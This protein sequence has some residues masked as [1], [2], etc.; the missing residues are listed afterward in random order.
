MAALAQASRRLP[1]DEPAQTVP[2]ERSGTVEHR[3]EVGGSRPR[4]R[5][6]TD[7]DRALRLKETEASVG[8]QE[9]VVGPFGHGKRNRSECEV[10]SD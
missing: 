1:P 6:G 9:R 8:V 3:R 5:P 4:T 10:S 7:V 2:E